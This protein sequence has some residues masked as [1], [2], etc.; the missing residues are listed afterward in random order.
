MGY[1]DEKW[2]G[3]DKPEPYD[4]EL[5]HELRRSESERK[6]REAREARQLRYTPQRS[7]PEPRLP[8]TLNQFPPWERATNP[9]S[10]A[11]E[12]RRMPGDPRDSCATLYGDG[13]WAAYGPGNKDRRFGSC[14]TPDGIP[15]LPDARVAADAALVELWGLSA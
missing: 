11:V 5:Y 8:Q 3:D 14:R 15:D 10:I 2:G 12:L 1:D 13:W 4:Y 7:A 6:A 9:L